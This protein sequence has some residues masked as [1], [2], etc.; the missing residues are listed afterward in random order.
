MSQLT[1]AA[2][3]WRGSLGVGFKNMR[4]SRVTKYG[5]RAGTSRGGVSTAGEWQGQGVWKRIG[6]RGRRL[7]S[8]P[9]FS[10]FV[11]VFQLFMSINIFF[12]YS[13]T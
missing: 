9:Y 12:I 1:I 4:R 6:V 3:K 5:A 2:E 13:Y 7:P 8:L 10:E 11:F